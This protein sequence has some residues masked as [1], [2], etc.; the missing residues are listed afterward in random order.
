MIHKSNIVKNRQLC[1][2]V[3]KYIVFG[4]SI[5]VIAGLELFD[6]FIKYRTVIYLSQPKFSKKYLFVIYLLF[7]HS[8]IKAIFAG[9]RLRKKCNKKKHE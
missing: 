6:L 1:Q 7:V 3:L 4:I 8:I 5:I 9:L 2:C